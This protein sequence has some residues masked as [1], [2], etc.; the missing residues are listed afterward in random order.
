MSTESTMT[1]HRFLFVTWEGGG[2]VPPILGLA[3]RL[4]ERGHSVRVISDPCNEGEVKAAG[5]E[6]TAYSRAPHRSDKSVGSTLAK[7]YEGS[8]V[9]GLRSFVKTFWSPAFAQDVLEELSTHPV[10]VCCV[11]DILM[12]ALFAPEKAGI[13][14]VLLMPNCNTLL[15]GPGVRLGG[16]AKVALQA[17]LFQR[18]ILSEGMADLRNTRKVL[19]LPPMR[20]LYTYIYQLSKVLIMT[21]RAFDSKAEVA[22][23][24]QYVG[25]IL[26][27]PTWT[28]AWQSPW[29]SDF[30]DPLVVVSLS[31]TYQ[32]QEDVLQKVLDALDGLKVRVLVTLGP[33]LDQTKFRIPA[34]VVVRQSVPHAQVFPLASVVVSHGGHGTVTR[35]LA[36]GVP[37]VCIPFG[38]DQPT[39]AE[40]VVAKGAGLKLDKKA[41]VASIRDVIQRVVKEPAFRENARQLGKTIAED[42]CNSTGV[43]VLEQ[44]AATVH[45]GV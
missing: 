20:S 41:S 8:P 24:Y 45:R 40:Y 6:F 39:N 42:A 9:A 36:S 23:N 5:C 31:T 37:L 4:V 14:T 18:I 19:G 13:H 29:S 10:D 21:S 11:N 32:H 7:D 27:D 1:P 22:L 44:V 28:E 43:Q 3:R 38:R 30:L 17:F 12:S 34:N 35:A 15:P 25:P 33:T 2:N 26:D 16:K